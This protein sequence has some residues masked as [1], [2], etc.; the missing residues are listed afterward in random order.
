[1]H[2]APA[3]P[4]HTYTY[5]THVR[6]ITP[7]ARAFSNPPPATAFPS[8]QLYALA[9]FAVPL[10][11]S[12]QN[13]ARNAQI[14]GRNEARKEALRLLQQ[15]DS[16]LQQKLAGAGALAQQNVISDR[17]AAAHLLQY[18]PCVWPVLPPP[19][20]V[21]GPYCHLPALCIARAATSL[22]FAQ[23]GY[24]GS[25]MQRSSPGGNS[26]ALPLYRLLYRCRDVVYR[27][28]RPLEE[29][30]QDFE[31]DDFEARLER[32]ARD[33]Q[34]TL[35]QAAQQQRPLGGSKQQDGPIPPP[36]V[37]WQQQQSQRQQ[38]RDRK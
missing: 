24:C 26:P 30:P 18:S 1:M 36:P 13:S 21:C 20:F 27:S 37:W 19:C 17:W 32:R 25:V 22:E 11:R 23:L 16:T 31:A 3:P 28:D 5:N 6:A 33:R 2:S 35:G 8:M 14:E 15:P 4:K 10:F 38:Q 7:V 34:P 29:Q 12:L 9:F